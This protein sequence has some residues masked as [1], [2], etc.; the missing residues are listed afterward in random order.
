[1]MLVLKLALAA[2][3]VACPLALANL[4]PSTPASSVGNPGLVVLASGQFR[5]R[6]A[7]E[8]SRDGR[9]SNA[10][11]QMVQMQRGLTIMTHQVT[12]PEYLGCV[13]DGACPS[14]PAASTAAPARDRPV[15][16]VSFH[17]A[18]AY[19]GWLSRNT[20]SH[21]RL[22]TDEEWAYAAGSRFA[23][24]VL[25]EIDGTDLTKRWIARYDQQSERERNSE[26]ETKPTGSFGMNEHG[27]LDIA[28]NVWEWTSTCFHR[29]ALTG[30]G[31][32]AAEPTVNC[33]VRVIEGR[34]RGYMTD[35]VRNPGDGG[36]AVGKPPSNLGFR[37][38]RDDGSSTIVRLLRGLLARPSAGADDR[39]M[40]R[41]I[42]S[43]TRPI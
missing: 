25:P 14:V 7:G 32:P 2:T 23:D 16:N 37:L 31:Q 22:P 11:L 30:D 43:D 19:A 1:M 33:G 18:E 40:G 35:F 10:P 3:A 8:F 15:V 5:Y 20:G 36:C 42:K 26:R 38:V 12:A 24:D 13:R 34:H 29:T 41:A 4:M 21:F 17:D 39:R 6:L 27:L 28:G 9:P